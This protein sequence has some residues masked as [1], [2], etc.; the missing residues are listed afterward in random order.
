MLKSDVIKNA[1]SRD[2][3]TVT[4]S[5]SQPYQTSD[6][7]NIKLIPRDN[8]SEILMFTSHPLFF[9]LS[10]T[11]NALIKL[12]HFPKFPPN[13]LQPINSNILLLK[14]HKFVFS[15]VYVNDYTNGFSNPQDN[16]HK[17]SCSRLPRS[18]I[19]K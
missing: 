10:P 15:P 9:F 11:S 6:Q 13:F 19:G 8:L 4:Y 3:T 14:E 16:N 12:S 5:Q 1:Q 17:M 18:N 7:G 2:L